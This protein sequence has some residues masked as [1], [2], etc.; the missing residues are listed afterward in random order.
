MKNRQG[1]VQV[2]DLH[3]NRSMQ[4]NKKIMPCQ[5]IDQLNERMT[6][7]TLLPWEDHTATFYMCKGCTPKTQVPQFCGSE[8]PSYSRGTSH[9]D[10]CFLKKYVS[11]TRNLRYNEDCMQV[12]MNHTRCVRLLNGADRREHSQQQEV[13][14]QHRQASTNFT[15]AVQHLFS[16]ERLALRPQRK[17]SR[18]YQP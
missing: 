13:W 8:G 18:C 17:E 2:K 6:R 11:W 1:S 5:K 4:Y 10:F 9:S 12:V 3:G 15:Q 16:H 14:Y 7:S